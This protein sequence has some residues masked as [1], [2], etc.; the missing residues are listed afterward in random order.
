MSSTFPTISVIIPMHNARATIAA[1]LDSLL[2]Q[3][4]PEWEAVI[5][6]DGS[7]D[8]G[9]DIAAAY[10]YRDSRI[11]LLRQAGA[12]PAAARNAGLSAA[13]GEFVAFLDAHDTLHPGA[14]ESLL[15]IAV[16]SPHRAA[17]GAWDY[18]TEAGRLVAWAES[19]TGHSVFGV[20]A[21]L[22]RGPFAIH[23]QIIHR[24][25]L[26][27]LRFDPA[28]PACSGVE[29]FDRLAARGVEWTTT[30]RVVCSR[31][32]RPIDRGTPSVIHR[33]QNEIESVRRAFGAA[34]AAGLADQID[35][36][37]AREAGALHLHALRFAHLALLDDDSADKEI[38]AEIFASVRSTL[39][40]TPNV[41]ATAI[42][43][44]Q[45]ADGLSAADMARQLPRYAAA[46]AAWWRRCTAEGWA[47]P[48]FEIQ[49][50]RAAAREVASMQDFSASLLD[51]C[52]AARPIVILGFGR[53]GQR[54]AREM[55]RRGLPVTV[56]DDGLNADA[57]RA[58]AGMTGITFIDRDQAYDPEPLYLLSVL[59]D[60][61]YLQ[62]L[63]RGLD[64]VRWADHFRHSAEDYLSKLIRHWPAE[65]NQT[66]ARLAA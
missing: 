11:R 56:R 49:A 66:Q 40:I 39:A 15:A 16:N 19:A 43:D 30:D 51:R 65:E 2:A 58:R 7:T 37:P 61:A 1:A 27:G 42:R 31:R 48:G 29:L 46:L 59:S 6:D 63:P 57:A 44:F 34:R 23:A 9:H 52:G 32:L 18:R 53:N 28:L 33:S 55:H 60:E 13:T 54:L 35:L 17:I 25:T 45:H 50:R 14:Y 5:V 41:A 47:G 36:S 8:G 21:L 62:R 26:A 12:G 38:A 3:T 4:M 22:N 20:D 10:A 64:L 24:D